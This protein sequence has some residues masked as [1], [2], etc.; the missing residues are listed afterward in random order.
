VL[1]DVL[2]NGETQITADVDGTVAPHPP[3]TASWSVD[4]L[5][6]LTGF[7]DFYPIADEFANHGTRVVIDVGFKPFL[8][9]PHL[10]RTHLERL[11]P[12][13]GTVIFS[14]AD[15]SA[16]V[17]QSH[18]DH[19]LTLGAE[20]VL[21][22]RGADGVD[23]T[24]SNGTVH[25]EGKPVKAIDTLGAGDSFTGGYL[26]G[27]DQGLDHLSATR[28]GQ[29]IAET[30]VSLFGRLPHIDDVPSNLFMAPA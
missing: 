11:A 14:G 15:M 26:A 7:P 2:N 8:S 10:L 30:K 1:A 3:A 27:R 19:A 17:R 13:L 18:A 23:V 9:E 16:P 29:R 5:T 24:D 4:Q 28:A 20:V 25:L 12:V 22:T 21:I 6:Y